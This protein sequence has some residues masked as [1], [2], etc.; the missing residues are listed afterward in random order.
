MSRRRPL[1]E[2]QDEGDSLSEQNSKQQEELDPELEAKPSSVCSA[3]PSSPHNP[4]QWLV[5]PWH[6]VMAVFYA[7]L[8]Y[9]GTSLVNENMHILDPA[10]KIPRFGG[11][12]KFLTH[13]NQWVQ[14]GFFIIQFVA[15][16]IPGCHRKS[17][18]K[19]SDFIFTCM[20]FPLAAVV[21]I[22]F[23]SIYAIDRELIYPSVYDIFVPTY[24]NH[25]WHTTV[26]LWVMFEIYV[27]HHHFTSK[28]TAAA[29][30]LVYGTGYITW[31]LYIYYKT[32][33]WVYGFMNHLSPPFMGAFFI[34]CMLFCFG[35]HVVG[36]FL[37]HARWGVTTYIE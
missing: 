11:R 34:I 15:D 8:L 14:L 7:L 36:K 26:L 19:V 21:V 35:A 16:I 3:P 1:S 29:C 23:W 9:Y 6:L 37:A 22:P 10:K 30:V 24:M 12:F 5:L 20:V 32:N 25:L 17:L 13:I 27:F 28:K 18:Q 4:L 2:P 33:W 31:V